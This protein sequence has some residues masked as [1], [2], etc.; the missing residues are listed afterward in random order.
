LSNDKIQGNVKAN[1][2]ILAD[3]E[4]RISEEGKATNKKAKLELR[5]KDGR[6]QI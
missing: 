2:T 5:S 4:N 6:C 1:Q 3:S